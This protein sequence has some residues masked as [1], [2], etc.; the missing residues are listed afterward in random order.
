VAAS[1]NLPA[2]ALVLAALGAVFGLRLGTGVVLTGAALAGV[3]LYL[4]GL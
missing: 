4:A 1:V 3:G 2:V